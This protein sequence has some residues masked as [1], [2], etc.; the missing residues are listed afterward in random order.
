ML[1]SIINRVKNKWKSLQIASELLRKLKNNTINISKKAVWFRLKDKRIETYYFPLI[2]FFHEAGYQIY[3][4]TRGGFLSSFWRYA[5]YL[6]ALERVVP[7]TQA[8]Q[9]AHQIAETLLIT[10]DPQI[11]TKQGNQQ[12]KKQILIS[13]NAFA[14]KKD[15]K[16]YDLFPFSMHPQHYGEK[17]A[18]AISTL[19][20]QTRKMRIFFSGNMLQEA[21]EQAIFKDFFQVLNRYEILHWL[22]EQLSEE[23][24]FIITQKKD[25]DFLAQTYQN[26]F[27]RTDWQ[28]SPT[29]AKNLEVRIPNDQWLRT[30]SQSDFF[31]ATPGIRMPMC[32]NVVE[33]MSVGTIPIIEYAEH[34]DPTLEHLHNCIVFKGKEDLLKKIRQVLAMTAEEINL[35]RKEVI[36][37]Y[38]QYHSPEGFVAQIEKKDTQQFTLYMYATEISL[39]EYFK[40]I[41]P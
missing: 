1:S 30:L 24:Q 31:L 19:R 9:I 12:Y 35:L 38:E 27:V 15:P 33:A 22:S 8:Q 10:D 6:Q 25:Y 39:Q 20:A 14:R 7:C 32:H 41:N 13:L 17:Y 26:K 28:W 29:K 34:F 5:P 4:D 11:L 40:N 3:L 37:Y 2:Y 16:P 18:A 23:E 21:Y 36:N